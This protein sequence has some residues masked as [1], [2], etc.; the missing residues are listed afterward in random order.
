MTGRGHVRAALSQRRYRIGG[1]RAR[2]LL[3]A[4]MSTLVLAGCSGDTAAVRYR[5]TAKIAVNGK[6]FEG[7]SV[8]QTSI[9]STPNSL[10][11]F[12][13]GVD[14]TGEGIIID[15]GAG[16]TVYVLLNDSNGSKRFPYIVMR[17]FE[18]GGPV[19]PDSV[20]LL[21]AVPVG[22]RC[23]LPASRMKAIMPLIVAFHDETVP[24]SIFVATE[25]GFTNPLGTVRL[26]SIELERVAADTPLTR[27]V[28][29]RLPWLNDIPFAG[30][31][32]RAL[33]PHVSQRTPTADMTL[34]Q[35]TTDRYFMDWE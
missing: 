24:K 16:K 5:A 19:A 25:P 29:Q 10:I 12:A 27:Q 7:S 4:G 14:D 13:L 26:V 2:A 11:G 3:L 35:R 23:V 17:C 33:D 6:P 21:K 28:A 15:V 32:V 9:T 20:A 18:N 1:S 31:I 8:R 22:T 30:S 34:A